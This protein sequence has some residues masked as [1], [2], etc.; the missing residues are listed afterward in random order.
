VAG[1]GQNIHCVLLAA[2]QNRGKVAVA[3][4]A[5][6]GEHAG[7]CG[8]LRAVALVVV[9]GWVVAMDAGSSNQQQ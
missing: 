7:S 1:E 6:V 9:G 2:T 5:E 8:G 4:A 3:E